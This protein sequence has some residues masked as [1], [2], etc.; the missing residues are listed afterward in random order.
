LDAAKL[1]G[2]IAKEVLPELELSDI[3]GLDQKLQEIEDNQGGDTGS[4]NTN[5][6]TIAPTRVYVLS[7]DDY[8]K[9][10]RVQTN[11]RQVTTIV[12]GDLEGAADIKVVNMGYGD[13]RFVSRNARIMSK[14]NWLWIPLRFGTVSILKDGSDYMISGDLWFRGCRFK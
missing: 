9:V 3:E 5:F 1:T 13:V 2:V 14:F 12:L 10:L 6:K 8:G 11:F 4:A 7:P